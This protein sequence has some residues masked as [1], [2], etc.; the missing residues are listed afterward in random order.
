M[1]K[2]Q[3]I[4]EKVYGKKNTAALRLKRTKLNNLLIE[5]DK[6]RFSDISI[7]MQIAFVFSWSMLALVIMLYI[8]SL[9]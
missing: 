7:P 5:R 8:K 3:E 2:N 9:I 4:I 6:V 1:V